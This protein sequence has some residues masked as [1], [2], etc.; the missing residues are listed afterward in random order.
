MTH[1]IDSALLPERAAQ[2]TRVLPHVPPWVVRRSRVADR[3]DLGMSGLLTLVTAATG[4]GKTQAV[5]KWATT[6]ELPGGLIWLNVA[7]QGADPDLFWTLLRDGLLEAGELQVVP[8]P[9]VGSSERQRRHAL[10]MLGTTLRRTGPWVVVLDDFPSGRFG[11]L[12]RDL[13]VVLDHAIRGLRLV[14]LSSGEPAIEIQRHH[15]AGQL[16]RV[17]GA[18]LAMDVTEVTDL[19]ARHGV[20]ADDL[21]VRLVQRHSHGWP[22]GVRLAALALSETATTEAAMDLADRAAVDYLASEVLAKT[23]GHVRDLIVR[24]SMVDEVSPELASAV[25][26]ATTEVALDPAEASKAFVDLRSDGSFRCHPLLRTAALAELAREPQGVAAEARRRAADWY[27]GRGDTRSALALATAAQDWSL[28][29]HTLVE[30]YVVPQILIGSSDE[31]VDSALAVAPVRAEEPLLQAVVHLRHGDLEAAE[32]LL[33]RANEAARRQSA[34]VAHRISAAFVAIGVARLSGD[35]DAGI[36][37]AAGARALITHV[38]DRGDELSTMLD[39]QLGALELC[40][41]AV[42]RA[43]LAFRQ[44]AGSVPR[45]G[46]SAAG[47]DCLGQLALLEAFQGSLRVAERYAAQILKHTAA[48][49]PALAHAHL[50]TAWVHLE[51]AEPTPARQHLDRAG[52]ADG[53]PVDPWFV[54][55]QQLA[56][57]RLLSLTNQPE[58]AL[59]LLLPEVSRAREAGQSGW[60]VAQLTLAAGE[61]LLAAGEPRRA[62]ELLTPGSPT[63]ALESGVLAASA[64]LELGEVE[65]A[66]AAL[67]SV[68]G[69]LARVPLSVQVKGWML[70][71]RLAHEAGRL[72]G[73]RVLVDRALRTAGAEALRRP[74]DPGATWL[75]ALVDGDVSLRRA[76]SGFLAGLRPPVFHPPPRTP[77]PGRSGLLVVETLTVRE[78]QVLGLLTEMCSTEEIASELFLSVN[79]V[80]TY[81]RGILRKLGVNRRVDAVRRGRELGLC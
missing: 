57:A 63:V 41:G 12:G 76:H 72:D 25:L 51:R 26:G 80:K 19:L 14:I 38:P 46:G 64:Q 42:H 70:E 79:T 30:S 71:A 29:A 61:A 69:D 28:V 44:G 65:A 15:V 5:A 23:P 39:A 53:C 10:T 40:R 31:P 13:E 24:T 4:W 81:V 59:R 56:E 75:T 52:E 21:T 11:Q 17:E 27:L 45:Q 67:A 50:A 49:D 36:E 33:G 58:A 43:A 20:E 18:E 47:F 60:L 66:R 73:A 34:T 6:A 7:G 2:E 37:M 62:L 35:A 74:V 8:I 55:V 78:S 54:L 68:A 9:D 3:L 48:A 1:A 77:D 16:T 22:C 32:V